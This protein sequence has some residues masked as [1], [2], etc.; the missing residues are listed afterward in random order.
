[1]LP[2]PEEILITFGLPALC[3]SG[4]KA[5]VTI[6]TEVRFVFRSVLYVCRSNGEKS[7]GG[8]ISIPALFMST[9]QFQQW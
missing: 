4:K 9:I 3:R 7:Y 6:A 1:M 5:A 2:R 8:R